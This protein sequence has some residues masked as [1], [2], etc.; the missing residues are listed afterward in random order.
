MTR[1]KL[2]MVAPAIA[3]ALTAIIWAGVTIYRDS[4][5]KALRDAHISEL[6]SELEA[7]HPGTRW[8]ALGKL[9]TYGQDAVPGL[10]RALA[11]TNADVRW[12]AA[13]SL[14]LIGP[15]AKEALPALVKLMSEDPD[16]AVREMAQLAANQIGGE[17]VTEAPTTVRLNTS[18]QPGGLVLSEKPQD[19]L[20][21]LAQERKS[22]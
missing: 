9:S 12:S 10:Q 22:P 13:G 4:R 15:Q 17:S 6:L 20:Q 3:I 5:Q 16:V 7:D 11:D 2:L 19:V 18:V 8:A 1:K 21:R 14:A